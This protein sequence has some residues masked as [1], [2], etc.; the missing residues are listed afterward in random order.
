MDTNLY[1]AIET[2][3]L[4]LVL[5]LAANPPETYESHESQPGPEAETVR[6]ASRSTEDVAA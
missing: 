1:S 2:G 4:S 3:R 5:S 6:P